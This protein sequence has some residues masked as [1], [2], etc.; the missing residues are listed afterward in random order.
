MSG[1]HYDYAY[2]KVI[3]FADGIERDLSEPRDWMNYSPECILK[4]KQIAVQASEFAGV[5]KD[6]EWLLSGDIGEETFLKTNGDKPKVKTATLQMIEEMARDAAKPFPEDEIPALWQM[7]KKHVP[8]SEGGS[9]HIFEAVYHLQDGV[10]T[11][12]WEIGQ[13]GEEPFEITFRKKVQ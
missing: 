2:L 1:G 13:K 4:L 5:M 6:V 8:Y 10:Y 7:L 9:F 3:E 12:L 11:A